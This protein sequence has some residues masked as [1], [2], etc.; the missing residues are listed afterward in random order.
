VPRLAGIA[1]VAAAAALLAAAPAQ[2]ARPNVIVVMTDDQGVA[3]TRHMPNVR[4]LLARRGTTFTSSF[5]SYPLCCPSRATYLTGQHAHNHG[6]E[7]N[8]F[9]SAYYGFRGK[10]NTL[11]V[12][13]RR[14]G[15]MTA[16]VGKY[17]NQYGGRDMREVPAGWTDW[18]G[19]IDFSTYDYFNYLINHNG[20]VKAYGDRDYAEALVEVNRAQLRRDIRTLPDL[21]GLVGRIFPPGYYG[22]QDARDY[23]TDVLADVAV[24]VVRKGTRSKRPFFLSFSPVAP[25]HED[26]NGIRP[27]APRPDPRPAP[28]HA[29]EFARKALPRPPSFNE[30]DVSDKPRMIREQAPLN[31]A[32]IEAIEEDHRGRLEALQSVDEAVGRLVRTLRRAGELDDTLIVFTSDNGWLEGQHRVPDNKYVPYEESIRVPLIVRGPGVPAGR[33]VGATAINVDL[34]ATIVDAANARAGRRLDGISL[35]PVARRPR[36]APRRDV[37]L[38]ALDPL[39]ADPSFPYDFAVPYHG[40]RTDR[41]KYVRW[42][43]GD[44]E[45]YDLRKDPYELANLAADPAH[46]ALKD[47]LARRADRLRRC[48]GR[49]CR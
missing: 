42:G 23:Q 8:F 2:A 39:F 21:L 24:D 1:A 25:H 18:H 30:Q 22:S 16:H 20:R 33:R 12:W 47:R 19:G 29:G 43:Y 34:A 32:Q 27:G 48:A 11:P 6:V 26:I 41:F 49:S 7:G 15:Y 14:A 45:L 40:V 5:S 46:A 17:L 3:D 44:E 35:L 10:R 38:E 4:R 13:L 28:R 31:D 36:S 9:P 37:P